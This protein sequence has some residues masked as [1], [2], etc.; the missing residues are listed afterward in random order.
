MPFQYRRKEKRK[1]WLREYI[2]NAIKQR[3]TSVASDPSVQLAMGVVSASTMIANY[4]TMATWFTGVYARTC[5]AVTTVCQ[6]PLAILPVFPV[7]CYTAYKIFKYFYED[8]DLTELQAILTTKDR[9]LVSEF[10]DRHVT[11]YDY[12][13]Y[14]EYALTVPL[15]TV[16]VSKTNPHA[17]MAAN[18]TSAENLIHNYA[19][20]FGLPVYSVSQSKKDQWRGVSGKRLQYDEK[21]ITMWCRDDD[22]TGHVVKMMDVDWF[23]EE[24]EIGEC[25]ADG[26]IVAMYTFTP[27]SLTYSDEHH[28]FKFTKDNRIDMSVRG[29]ARYCHPLWNWD[30]D[31]VTLQIHDDDYNYAPNDLDIFVHAYVE[32]RKV[33]PNRSV[34][35]LIPAVQ[36]D[37]YARI[38]QKAIGIE[39]TGLKRFAPTLND[40]GVQ[41]IRLDNEYILSHADYPNE[42]RANPEQFSQLC[43]VAHFKESALSAPTVAR[44]LELKT[45]TPYDLRQMVLSLTNVTNIPTVCKARQPRAYK[46]EY[47]NID[48]EVKLR[49]QNFM[50]PIVDACFVPASCRSNDVCCI[51]GRIVKIR[52]YGRSVH[53]KYTAYAN[54][55]AQ[56]MGPKG[57]LMPIDIGEVINS[58]SSAQRVKYERASWFP[59]SE[60]HWHNKAFQKTEGYQEIKEPRNISAVDTNHVVNYLR[61]VNAVTQHMGETCP[62]YAFKLNPVQVANRVNAVCELS[63]GMAIETD[64][65]RFDGTQDDFHNTVEGI[66]LFHLFD[67]CCHAELRA[68]RNALNFSVFK[69]EYG[70]RY[71]TWCTRKSGSADTSL[72]NTLLNAYMCYCALRQSGL[73][74][75]EAWR[76]LGV[77]G[78]D[79]G[80]TAHVPPALLE[81]VCRDLGFKLK[82]TVRRSGEA[83]TF[84]GRIFPNPWDNNGSFIDPLRALSKLHFTSDSDPC[85]SNETLAW[86]KAVSLYVTDAGNFVGNIAKHLL[87]ISV[88]GRTEA[89]ERRPWM[90][91]VLPENTKMT[92]AEIVERFQDKPVF[93]PVPDNVGVQDQ[94]DHALLYFA[95]QTQLPL[96]TIAEW[97]VRFLNAQSL[98]DI[99]TL[100]RVETPSNAPVCTSVDGVVVGPRMGPAPSPPPDMKPYCRH[101]IQRRCTRGEK[102]KYSHAQ[103]ACRDHLRGKCAY[104]DKCKFVHYALSPKGP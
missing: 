77:Y 47:S 41:C 100:Y 13:A 38:A 83:V 52:Q 92:T 74:P 35:F 14:R 67:T 37:V 64:F 48:D 79:D 54:E 43:G 1:S 66:I 2:E 85:T 91:D 29:G 44:I 15:E 5:Q 27:E 90:R 63:G 22:P 49:G 19:Q 89:V 53:P 58:A 61:F 20:H 84:L 16:P 10:I 71:N 70:I 76:K 65:S 7:V 8:P 101:H 82:A 51:D 86:R 94:P 80:V 17:E 31:V 75:D 59:F 95:N 24:Q 72:G 3:V 104:A 87:D 25:L 12:S 98:K 99:P 6:H 45:D 36:G 40:T 96:P 9:S 73:E 102:C 23:L 62:W 93:P 81:H 50:P 46:M 97:F 34:V 78:G 42:Y 55:F 33:S 56:L 39:Y 68:L 28:H 57:S 11:R 18:R 103:D 21:D 4:K 69:T 26:K 60:E 88:S 32:R 30:V